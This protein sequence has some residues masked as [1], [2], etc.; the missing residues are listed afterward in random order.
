M[1]C[2]GKKKHESQED[3]RGGLRISPVYFVHTSIL[4]FTSMDTHKRD[5]HIP[6]KRPMSMHKYTKVYPSIY[7]SHICIHTYTHKH[8]YTRIHIYTSHAHI[9][10]Y[11]YASLHIYI[12]NT[13]THTHINIHIHIHTHTYLFIIHTYTHTHTRKHLHAYTN[14]Q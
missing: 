9:H 5:L 1:Q 10:A 13:Q 8:T 4:K 11:I 7:L 3:K 6:Q 14:P 2:V 12:H